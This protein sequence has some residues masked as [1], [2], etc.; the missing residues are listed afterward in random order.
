[1]KISVK[2]ENYFK[3]TPAKLKAAADTLLGTIL[4]ID[5]LMISMPEFPHK[6]WVVWSWNAFVVLFKFFTKFTTTEPAKV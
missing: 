4:V 3:Q 1:M 6:E 2:L 5:P